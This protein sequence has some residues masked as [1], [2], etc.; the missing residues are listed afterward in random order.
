M[1]LLFD[2]AV[3]YNLWIVDLLNLVMEENTMVKYFYFIH[4]IINKTN[5]WYKSTKFKIISLF[6]NT[7]HI[8]GT[9][10]NRL[11]ETVLLSTQNNV[12]TDG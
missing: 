6:L 8:V 10:K 2:G 3:Y 1:E 5:L 9:Q 11:N 7:K 4:M 12:W